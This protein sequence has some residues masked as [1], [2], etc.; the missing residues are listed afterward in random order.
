MNAVK[1]TFTNGQIVPAEP[2]D[3][4]EGTVLVV[5]PVANEEIF[6]LREEDWRTDPEAVADWLRWYE[7]LEPLEFTP[8]EET[9]ISAWRQ[10][11]KEF[12]VANMDNSI[13]GLF[14]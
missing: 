12:T 1:A 14:R 6:G 13:E 8:E 5:E 9:E 3:W 10:K 2:V 11:T 7:S 4:P